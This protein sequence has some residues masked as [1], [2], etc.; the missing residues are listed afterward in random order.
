MKFLLVAAAVVGCLCPGGVAQTASPLY[1]RGYTVIPEPQKVSLEAGEFS[2]GDGWT[3][4]LDP[5]VSAKDV[6]VEALR[7]GLSQR[8]HVKLS[9]AGRSSGVLSLRIAP[10]SVAIGKAQDENKSRLEEQAYRINLRQGSVAI[11]A[12]ASTGL[13]YGVETLIQLLRPVQAALTL[14][15]GTIEDWPDLELRQVY[16]DDAHHLDKMDD[17]KRAM[18]QASFYKMNGFVIKLE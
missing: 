8:F 16:W 3:L 6:A 11:T 4:H 12:N 5:S 14:P 9:E 18:K 17:L 13:F 10:G 1:A 15:E 7:E 2:F